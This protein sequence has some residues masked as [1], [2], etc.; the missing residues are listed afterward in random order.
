K[1]RLVARSKVV[2][3][4]VETI[5]ICLECWWT[6]EINVD[7]EDGKR[8]SR[9]GGK[10]SRLQQYERFY[11]DQ[12]SLSSWKQTKAPPKCCT[13]PLN[14]RSSILLLMRTTK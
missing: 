4:K 5:D 9:E 12:S 1:S 6:K 7:L 11:Q 2:N 10:G 8:K 3:G 13:F 14:P